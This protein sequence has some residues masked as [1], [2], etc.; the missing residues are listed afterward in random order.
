MRHN[1]LAQPRAISLPANHQELTNSKGSRQAIVVIL[2]SRL[3][4]NGGIS[5]MTRLVMAFACVRLG[6]LYTIVFMQVR[7][8][9][10]DRQRLCS[11]PT[12]ERLEDPIGL[13]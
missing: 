7:H 1:A 9:Q 13:R 4:G 8:V 10:R 5:N 2:C 11:T 3:L 12:L 6:A